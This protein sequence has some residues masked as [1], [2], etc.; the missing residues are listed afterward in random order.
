MAAR[1]VEIANEFLKQ[2]GALGVLT[3][4]QLQKLCFFA[5]GWNWVINK[6]DLISD[7]AEAWMYGPVF[8]DLYDHTK[9]FGKEPIGRLITPDDDDSFKFFGI[10]KKESREYKANISKAQEDVIAHVWRRY[11]KLPGEQL[12][13]LTHEPE[14]PWYK[15]IRRGNNSAL[16]KEDLLEY[17]NNLA[18][19]ARGV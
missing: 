4:M 17:F 9:F 11:G 3:Q 13:R 12:S 5:D 1:A 10:L 19:L 6:D 14:S 2:P 16:K 7:D 18:E 15:A 8:R